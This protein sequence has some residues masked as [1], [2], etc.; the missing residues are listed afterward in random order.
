MQKIKFI[1]TFSK[2]GY[3][4][5]GQSW[6]ESF[7]EFTKNN[8]NITAKIYIDGDMN[9]TKLNYGE[10]VEIVDFHEKIPTHQTWTSL[11]RKHSN[12][13]EYQKELAVKFSFK[14]FV[15]LNELKIT[16][17][18]Y[19]VWLDADSIF[20]SYDFDTFIEETI[21]DKFMACQ[22]EKSSE[23]IESGIVI[24][25]SAHPD[26][27]KFLNF[28]ESQYMK[29]ENFNSYGHLYDGY[30]IYR[31]LIKTEIS[32]VD[33][34][35]NYGIEGIQSDPNFTFLNPVIR[36]RFY[37]NI[38][39]TGKKNYENW[40]KY[41]NKDKFFKLL[42]ETSGRCMREVKKENLDKIKLKLIKISK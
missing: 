5:Y 3:Y 42:F 34:N 23:H 9:L 40:K 6:I 20:R 37:H 39:I 26:K 11:F 35:L 18:E 30:V 28:F 7:L 4:V 15:I 24:F 36:K 14:A 25:N 41:I 1:T 13:F 31:S 12:H 10:K 8:S 17:D 16:D 27:E 21:N 19:V 38:G 2:S 33:L 22:K 29:I 32:Y